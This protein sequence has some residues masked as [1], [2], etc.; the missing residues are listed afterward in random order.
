MSKKTINQKGKLDKIL[1]DKIEAKFQFTD[2]PINR[3]NIIKN[4]IQ[5]DFKNKNKLIEELKEQINSI[6][7]CNLKDNSKN[8]I[9]GEGDINSPIMIIGES[10]GLEEDK[11]ATIFSGEIGELLNK[12]LAAI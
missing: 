5:D 9:F 10:P 2:K 1:I 11:L 4:K 7:N 3:L 6:E 8:I 12:M